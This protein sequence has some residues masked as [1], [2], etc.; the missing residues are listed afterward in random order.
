MPRNTRE[1][2]EVFL[3]TFLIVNMLDEILKNYTIIQEF[4]QT[5]LGTADD[6]EDSEKRREMRTVGAKNHYN[7]YLYLACQ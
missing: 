1:K 4:W 3:E 7:Q 5:P 6:V 2:S